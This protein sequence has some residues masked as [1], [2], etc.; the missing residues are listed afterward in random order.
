M[1]GHE[2]ECQ[3]PDCSFPGHAEDD[4]EFVVQRIVGRKPTADAN[5]DYLWLIKWEGYV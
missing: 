2:D 5:T 4:G 3:R 1:R